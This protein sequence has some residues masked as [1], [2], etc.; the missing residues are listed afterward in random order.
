[1]RLVLAGTPDVALPSLTALLASDHDV[2]GVVTRPN[3]AVG[4]SKKLVPS[5]IAKRALDLGL[6]VLR[7]DHPRDPDF[8]ND[9][10]DL[11]PDLVPV[12]AYGALLPPSALE[13][14]P[15]GW[16]N[17]HFSLLPAWRGAAPVQRALMAGARVTGVTTFL[18]EAGLDSGPIYKQAT[19]PIEPDETAGDLLTRLAEDGAGVLLDTVDAI[20]TGA[21]PELQSVDG[22]SLAPKVSVDDAH[23]DWAASALRLHNQIRGC[24]PQ[25]GAWTTYRSGRFKILRSRLADPSDLA[26][27][28]VGITKAAVVVGTGAGSLELIQVQ[29]VGKRPMTAPEWARGLHDDEPWLR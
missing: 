15:F 23:L 27:G 5:P 28:Q 14:P 18:I 4:R 6:P 16:V 2:V 1:M 22:V 26:P 29:P 12:V 7:P 19:A 24:S 8:Q 3:A 10:R 21:V 11:G 25:P 13:I 20:G 9:L 17:L